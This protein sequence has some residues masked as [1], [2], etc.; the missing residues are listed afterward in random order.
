MFA[1]NGLS[2]RL[3]RSCIFAGGLIVGH[4][5]DAMAAT[6]AAT[7]N[8]NPRPFST[9]ACYREYFPLALKVSEGMIPHEVKFYCA[10]PWN[11]E[12]FR[13]VREAL[14]KR[15]FDIVEAY[16]RAAPAWKQAALRTTTNLAKSEAQKA[17][18][19][20]YDAWYVQRVIPYLHAIK[21][22]TDDL[23]VVAK[24]FS[25]ADFKI[26]HDAAQEID[27]NQAAYSD[28]NYLRQNTGTSGKT[29]ADVAAIVMQIY[30]N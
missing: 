23:K 21:Y 18:G 13:R 8:V 1:F 17:P 16:V 4:G 24:T 5:L 7:S 28:K 3:L 11:F 25:P 2:N 30:V 29:L 19:N 20:F 27:W 22:K 12:A 10:A 14:E 15:K 6:P 9:E 26:L